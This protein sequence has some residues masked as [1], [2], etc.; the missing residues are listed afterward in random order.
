MLYNTI[1]QTYNRLLRPH[2][3][4]K[5]GVYNGVP[6]RGPKLLDATDVKHDHE[7]GLVA[8]TREAISPGD[9]VVLVGGGFGTSAVHASEAAGPYGSVHVY[10][11]SAEMYDCL[12]D[13]LAMNG[14]DNVTAHHAIVGE[15]GDV[16]GD[17][18]DP[19]R[20]SADAVPACDVLQLDCEGAEL[21][22][23]DAIPEL[24]PSVVVETHGV[25]GASTDAVC[26]V[27]TDRGYGIA[28]VRDH[29][30]GSE[31]HRDQDVY[32]VTAHA[33]AVRES[34]T[35]PR[36]ETMATKLSA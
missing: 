16:W 18:G 22:L 21:A 28:G 31:Y 10:E 2:L 14:C 12:T 29:I 5:V 17:L 9:D 26:A 7:A 3:P 19:A 36:T 1:K 6:V 33:D 11:A 23:L 13:T 25:Y 15:P 8:A 32:I 35:T 27:L 34:E 4:R 30:P 24:P 20:V